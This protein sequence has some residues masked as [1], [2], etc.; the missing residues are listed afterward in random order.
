MKKIGIIQ[1][2]EKDINFTFTKEI[3]EW[4]IDKGHTPILTN[5]VSKVLEMEHLCLPV[6]ELYT[7]ADFLLVLGGDGTMLRT[8][9][10]AAI[11]NLPI[12]GVNL[13]TL[14]YLTNVEKKDVYVA[15]Q[16]VLGGDFTLEKRMMLSVSM[17]SIDTDNNELIALNDVCITKSIFS[18]LINL[19]LFINDEYID[20]YRADGI[21]VSTPTGSTAYNL[22]AGGPILN[23][24][25]KMIA[26]TPICP[27]MLHNRPFVVS[28]DDIIQFKILNNSSNDVILWLDGQHITPLKNNDIINI[29][30]SDYFT[31]IIKTDSL[32]F[33]D[34]LRKKIVEVRK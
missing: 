8:A 26:I 33:Y 12:L 4:I 15:L 27:H 32:G 5:H 19:D 34:I 7:N 24:T 30:C 25:S 1:N 29:K 31:N 13:G 16:K 17:I 3:A 23:P 21:I 22:S 11:N 14:G 20:T 10:Y 18:K 2:S 28:A 9:K 6:S